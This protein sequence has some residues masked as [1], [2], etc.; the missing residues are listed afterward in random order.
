MEY[1][2]GLDFGTS[3]VR[4][5][6]LD[7][8]SGQMIA[9]AICAFEGGVEGTYLD[10]NDPLLA[11]QSPLEYLRSMEVAVKETVKDFLSNG[12]VVND[13][14]G[15]G[16]D[17]TGS[18]PI[19]VKQNMLPLVALPEFE[20]NLN[21]Y[22]WLWKDHTAIKEALEI[23][24]KASKNRP[25]YLAKCGGNYSSEWFWSKIWHCHN[26]DPQTFA[27]ADSW[28]EQSDFIPATLAG[29]KDVS[30][31]KRNICA[32]GH[33]AMF[34]DAWGGLP[35][36]EFLASLHPAL[37]ALRDRLYDVAYTFEETLGYLSGE[38]AERLGL[39][40][41]IPIAVGALD[42]HVGAIG[43]GVRDGVFVKIIGTST[44]DI[45]AFPETLAPDD[46]PG[47]AGIVNGSVLPGH[48]GVE[49]G[50]AAVGDLLN[51]W[52]QHV[53]KKEVDYHKVLT[54]KASKLKAGESGLLALDWNNGNRNILGDQQLSGLILGQTLATTDFEIYRALIEATAFGA[55]KIIQLVE[56]Q[57]VKINEV[58]ATG[59][60]GHKNEMFMQIYAD[61]IGYPVRLV[62]NPQTVAIG[63]AIMAAV[64]AKK[65]SSE[66]RTVQDAVN[67]LSVASDKTYFPVEEE[68][69]VYKHLFE[70]Y[71]Q[72]HNTFGDSHEEGLYNV[73]KELIEIRTKRSYR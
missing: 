55:L 46:F 37:A 40:E 38:W 7:I 45:M 51:W 41:G 1:A 30:Q 52:V 70:L 50:Q 39:P 36:K 56:S 14:I 11:R 47:V 31:V 5:C 33:K 57:G 21:A 4:A 22:A 18:T 66:F 72:L 54:D 43:A 73:M 61:V 9:T 25:E 20:N 16:V 19:P 2:L 69:V 26:V 15:I 63:A 6:L 64:A 29:I 60:I 35:D 24:E 58:I 3:S 62:E 44:C 10:K 53:L 68:H 28:I 67:R 13:I 42:A 12:H 8:H 34:S 49:A 32:A 71:S 48:I 27:A 59:G 17:A 23:T 65:D